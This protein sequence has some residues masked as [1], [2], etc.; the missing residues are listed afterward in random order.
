MMLVESQTDRQLA[1]SQA[2]I[3]AA[4]QTATQ[5]A[6]QTNRH[7]QIES[8]AERK[9]DRQNR[10]AAKEPALVIFNWKWSKIS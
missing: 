4:R 8:Q 7:R 2:G 1:A 10:G 6:R 3:W 5:A 9:S